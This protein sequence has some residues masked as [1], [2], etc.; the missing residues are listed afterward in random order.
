MPSGT[1]RTHGGHRWP[2]S[3][4]AEDPVEGTA[5]DVG[6]PVDLGLDQAGLGGDPD[7]LVTPAVYGTVVSRP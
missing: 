4:G 3:P 2:A 1:R 6:Q 7:R 5:R